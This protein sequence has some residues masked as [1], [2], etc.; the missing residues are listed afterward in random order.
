MVMS[1]DYSL[2]TRPTCYSVP[3]HTMHGGPTASAALAASASRSVSTDPSTVPEVGLY[4]VVARIREGLSG[5][6]A[7]AP[8]RVNSVTELVR[9]SG[10][11][12]DDDFGLADDNLAAPCCTSPRHSSEG[13]RQDGSCRHDV[14]LLGP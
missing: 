8:L 14:D 5:G 2:E 6:A 1:N 4:F 3:G 9:G 12:D 10:R 11:R 7:A 13:S